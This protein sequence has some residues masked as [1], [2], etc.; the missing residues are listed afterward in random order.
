MKDL[1]WSQTSLAPYKFRVF[2]NCQKVNK[3]QAAAEPGG[4][5]GSAELQTT[6]DISLHQSGFW[7]QAPTGSS[8]SLH[9]RE[10]NPGLSGV[11]DTS[12]PF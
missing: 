3:D 4:S 7:S 11:T 8:D 1:V 12:S 6:L 2:L 9:L 5:G 10:G